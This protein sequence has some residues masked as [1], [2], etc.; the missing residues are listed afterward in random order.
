M[1]NLTDTSDREIPKGRLNHRG[2]LDSGASLKLACVH[3]DQNEQKSASRPIASGSLARPRIS[4]KPTAPVI[5][6]VSLTDTG[7]SAS[8]SQ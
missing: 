8:L 4:L 3:A 1:M 6:Q 2:S 5:S 7:K